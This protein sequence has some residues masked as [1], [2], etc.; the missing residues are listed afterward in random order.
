[1]GEQIKLRYDDEI[2]KKLTLE[3]QELRDR[4]DKL[5][6]FIT[7]HKFDGPLTDSYLKLCQKQL[8]AMQEYRLAL[9][10]RRLFLKQLKA[11]AK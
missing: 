6:N 7:Y 11:Q 3:L 10:D 8:E 1:M 2:L 4:E 5:E 9:A